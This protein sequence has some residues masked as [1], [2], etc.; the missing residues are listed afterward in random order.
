[1]KK[2]KLSIAITAKVIHH[3]KSNV[4]EDYSSLNPLTDDEC[5]RHATLAACYQLAQSFL[6]LGLHYQKS[7][8]GGGGR[9]SAWG[10]MHMAA[11]LAGC[12]KALV[13]TG[14]STGCRAPH[15]SCLG[16]HERA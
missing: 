15:G 2:C 1:M 4:G 13:G 14:F 10:V 16:W 8:I 12:R 11:A 3:Q 9:V 5:T 6:M 7:R